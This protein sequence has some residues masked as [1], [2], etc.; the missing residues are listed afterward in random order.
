MDMS[1]P[2]SNL[3]GPRTAVTLV[4][5]FARWLP[6]EQA[7]LDWIESTP[8]GRS[9]GGAFRACTAEEVLRSE[10]QHGKSK[11]IY[12]VSYTHLTLPTNREV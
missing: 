10:R 9:I 5:C 1:A 8:H 3:G 11:N 6:L 12:T 4:C 2:R 7:A